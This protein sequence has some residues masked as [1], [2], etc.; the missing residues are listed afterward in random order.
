MDHQQ[1]HGLGYT[2]E[3]NGK[4]I[5]L[6]LNTDEVKA[7]FT[8]A[9]KENA[10]KEF[11]ELKAMFVKNG[12]PDEARIDKDWRE[13]RDGLVS[14]QYQWGGRQATAWLQGYEGGREWLRLL[15][16]FGGSDL[17]DDKTLTAFMKEKTD[18]IKMKLELIAEESEP[19]K[20]NPPAEMK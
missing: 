18:E 2:I 15:M 8:A 20:E 3:W 11:D 7:A 6:S 12:K 9:C 1:A 16:T 14:G 17:M 10:L 5:K 13:V 4:K 19:P